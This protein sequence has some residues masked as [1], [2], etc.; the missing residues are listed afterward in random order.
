MIRRVLIFG[1]L[2][3]ALALSLCAQPPT[4]TKMATAF[5]PD[6]KFDPTRDPAQDLRATIAEAQASHRLILLDVGGQWC[7]W[8]KYF[9]H[10]FEEHADLRKFR[11]EH[12]VV[13]KVNFSRENENSAFLTGYP[14]VKGYP[15]LFVLDSDG[16]LL[17]SQDTDVL[18]QGKGYNPEAVSK[19]LH[20]WAKRQKS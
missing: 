12:F 4:P 6:S 7:S 18:E 10:F 19:F 2:T 5:G 11:D 3:L 14:K 1:F 8:C 15:H 16:K 9:D 20:T 13:M 17:H